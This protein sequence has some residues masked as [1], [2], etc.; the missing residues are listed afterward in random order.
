MRGKWV[1]QRSCGPH[2]TD[3][4]HQSRWNDRL[5]LVKNRSGKV[6]RRRTNAGPNVHVNLYKEAQDVFTNFILRISSK[7]SVSDYLL[8]LFIPTL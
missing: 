2:M 4:I 6:I 1:F 3:Y 7:C 5:K 8:L